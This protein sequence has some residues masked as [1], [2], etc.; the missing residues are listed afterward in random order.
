VIKRIA[1]IVFSVAMTLLL[2]FGGVSKEYL[3]LFTGH[4]DTTHCNHDR[5]GLYFESEHHHCDFLSFT[6]PP[7]VHDA[8]VYKIPEPRPFYLL[9]TT[10]VAAHLIPRDAP[11]SRLRGPPAGI[12]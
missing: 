4:T 7:F 9:H 6:L 10:E 8:V 1:H 12:L 2:V 11:V 5:E 3:H